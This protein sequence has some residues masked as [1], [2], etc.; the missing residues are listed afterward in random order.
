MA[1][2]GRVRTHRELLT[3]VWGPASSGDTQYLHVFINQLN[4]KLHRRRESSRHILTEP[5]IGYRFSTE[6]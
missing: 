3:R 2:A 6:P 1:I 5:G 4:R